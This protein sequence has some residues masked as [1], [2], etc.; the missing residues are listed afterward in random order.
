M[1][2]VQGEQERMHGKHGIQP[3]QTSGFWVDPISLHAAESAFLSYKGRNMGNMGG[4]GSGTGRDWKEK[5]SC[6]LLKLRYQT[7]NACTQ[8]QS[9][10]P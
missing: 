5:K 6:Q 10:T 8:L 3:D 7:E 4:Q 9:G 2:T 1:Y